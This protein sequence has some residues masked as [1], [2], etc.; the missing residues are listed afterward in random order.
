MS[1]SQPVPFVD[2]GLQHR[3]IADQVTAGFERVLS[4]TSFI[5][6]PE[7]DTFERAFAQYCGVEHVVGVG[8][9]TD[10]LE[11]ALAAHD[12]GPG[13]EVVIPANTFVATAEAVARVGAQIR[14]VDCD[15][16]F[17]LDPKQLEEAVTSRTRAVAAVH[18][19]GQTAA[20][21]LIREVV[22]PDVLV[23]ED[24]AQ[25]QG[26]RRHGIRA[27]ALGDVAATSF[28]PGKNLGAYGDAG[29]V[30]TS[31]VEVADRVRAIGNHGGN[32]KYEHSVI[33]RNSRLDGL[34]AVVLT[35]KLR[36]LDE[37]NAERRAAAT[38][39][40]ELLADVEQVQRPVTAPGNEHVFHLYVVR[41][42]ERDRVAEHL[43]G[44]GIGAGVHY[45]QPI[46]QIP[47]FD[48]L[49]V[50]AG[51]F[52]VTEQAAPELLSL[53]MFPGITP[54]QQE[55]VAEAVRGAWT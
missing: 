34:Q 33:G 50:P 16:H 44:A 4:A 31:S 7:A 14:L 11:M 6:G 39:Y 10:A 52:P 45:P 27:G 36:V 2:L 15:E 55:R 35:E 49:A 18:L 20:V 12:I 1:D 21:E 25:S 37:W 32:R 8:N 28:Y 13:D 40:D 54:G 30:M 29:A 9:G 46:H 48:F 19:Y 3:R 42:P 41:V 22:G 24:A 43:A 53:P 17:L 47:A 38:R 26:A 23:L 5:R 51:S